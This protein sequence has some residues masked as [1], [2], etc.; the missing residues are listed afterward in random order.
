[1]PKKLAL[2]IGINN[3]PGTSND[4]NGCVNDANDWATAF[5]K[6]GYTTTKLIDKKATKKGMMSAMQQLIEPAQSGDSIVIQY[7]GHGSYVPDEDGDEA[8]GTDECICPHDITSNGFITD[9]ELFDL[10]T[11]KARGVRLVMFSDSCNS[12]TVTK[13]APIMTPPT[14]KGR[15]PP[16][17]KVRFLPPATFLASRELK[18]LGIS[19]AFRKSSPPGRYGGLLVAGC[20]DTEFSYDAVFE[21]RPNGAF[22]FV[23][24]ATLKKLASTATYRTW[25]KAMQKVLPSQQ[26][27]QSPNL[28]GS[29][30]MK[31]WRVLS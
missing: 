27:P 31:R 4:L 25:F 24:L 14:M 29:S 3:Y 2:C 6:H 15:K 26:Y 30:T 23:A 28:Y 7:S 12:G 8:D 13:F 21:G 11:S 19:K 22:T 18:K 16:V 1:M 5:T 17:R 10:F 20:Q 9:D